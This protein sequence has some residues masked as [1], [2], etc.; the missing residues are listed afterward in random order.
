LLAGRLLE[1]ARKAFEA[2]IRDEPM[3]NFDYIQV[4]A[5]VLTTPG[6]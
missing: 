4:N 2:W 5:E 1:E 3:V 6:R